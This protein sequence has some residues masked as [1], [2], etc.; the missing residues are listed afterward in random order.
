MKILVLVLIVG[1]IAF[2]AILP[3]SAAGQNG[4]GKMF[5]TGPAPQDSTG[6]Q[7]GV[8]QNGQIGAN[9]TCINENCPNNGIPLYDGTGL[10][11]GKGRG[12]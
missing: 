11:Y 8:G 12:V 2:A 1:L 9:G 4:N 7:N 3:A 10:Q 5:K 6:N